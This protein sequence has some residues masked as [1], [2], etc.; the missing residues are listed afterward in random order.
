MSNLIIVSV[1]NKFHKLLYHICTYIQIFKG[2]N[3]LLFRS[4]NIIHEIF[5]LEISLAKTICFTLIEQDTCEIDSYI[6]I[7]VTFTVASNDGKFLPSVLRYIVTTSL[8][9]TTLFNLFWTAI[10]VECD[11]FVANFE[12]LN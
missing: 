7:Y 9:L 1:N 11:I 10:T 8:G 4:Q 3:F 2:C 6:R 12:T 5:I